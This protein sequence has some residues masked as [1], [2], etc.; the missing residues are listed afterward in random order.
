MMAQP[1]LIALQ[2]LAV[3]LGRDEDRLWLSHP[4]APRQNC[5]IG[6]HPRLMV[7]REELSGLIK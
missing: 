4:E 2:D 7:P 3:R 1:N 5:A 6:I